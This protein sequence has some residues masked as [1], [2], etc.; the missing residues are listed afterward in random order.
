L[1]GKYSHAAHFELQSGFL[2]SNGTRQYPTAA[3]VCNFSK[4]T[5][6]KPSLLEQREVVTLF[7]EL[8]HA[9]HNLVGRT[10]YSCLHGTSVVRD[11]VEAPSQMLEN[12]CW[13]PYVLKSLSS[14]YKTGEKITDDLIEKLIK[15]RH[16]NDAIDYL[17]RIHYSTFDMVVHTP[18]SHEEAK[19][20]KIPELYNELRAQMLDL[21]SPEVL[22]LPR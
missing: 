13:V 1:P 14:H 20:M 19:S 3:L 6:T 9:I 12:W 21:S 8:G 17:F 2:Y 5:P 22:G 4:P 18:K 7:H 11:F 16:T 10:I 15:T